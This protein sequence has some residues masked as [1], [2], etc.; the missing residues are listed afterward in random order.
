[1]NRI[2]LII[3][4][5]LFLPVISG[6]CLFAQNKTICLTTDPWEPYYGPDLEKGGVFTEI[7]R[8]A[9][10]IEGYE[11]E[12]KFVPWKRALESSKQ[13]ICSGLLGA[14]YTEER[15]HN[16]QYSDPITETRIVFITKIDKAIQYKRLQELSSYT[17]GTIRGYSYS[18]EFDSAT[19]LKKEEVTTTEQNLN[20]LLADRID[21]FIDSEEVAAWLLQK[22][23]KE[24]AHL[25]RIIEPV[26][27]VKK[28]YVPISK[29]IKNYQKIVNDLNN[30]I[31]KIKENGTYEAILEHFPAAK[32]MAP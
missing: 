20:K 24:V 12:V 4:F 13:G 23:F 29:N 32:A 17:I 18:Q 19:Y 9:F 10:K 21:I 7:V 28:L 2:S 1:M 31:K 25:V 15:T 30:G 16:F 11:L 27:T 8:A 3:F 14:F 26:Y 22:K 6:N 5:A